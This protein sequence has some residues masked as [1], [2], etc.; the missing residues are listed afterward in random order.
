MTELFDPGLQL[1]RTQLA[2]RRTAL[3]ALVNAALIVKLG[4]TTVVPAAAYVVG[5]LLGVVAAG[6]F[7]W[8]ELSYGPR[9]RALLAG[10]PAARA[11]A[12][13]VLWAGSLVSGGAA[14]L[15]A[16]GTAFS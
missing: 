7:A 9:R 15:L 10:R 11:A 3:T 12:L 2:W 1:E 16:M 6:A 5:A 4:A 8:G 14:V 13:R